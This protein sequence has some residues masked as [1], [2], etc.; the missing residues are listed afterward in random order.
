MRKEAMIDLGG[1]FSAEGTT[2]I[3]ALKKECAWHRQRT[4]RVQLEHS[5]G[6]ERYKN[7]RQEPDHRGLV[8]F[9]KDF[10]FLV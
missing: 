2:D 10:R 9:G 5:E 1:A 3:K 4:A 6:G 7:G 8:A